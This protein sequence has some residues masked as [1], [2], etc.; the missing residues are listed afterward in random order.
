MSVPWIPPSAPPAQP[1]DDGIFAPASGA[2]EV[3][4]PPPPSAP[5]APKRGRGRPPGQRNLTP[6]ERAQRERD[7]ANA[8]A[9]AASGPSA[10]E[11]LAKAKA[12]A[13]SIKADTE[14]MAQW[15]GEELNDYIMQA[16]I[17]GGVPATML[18]KDG[19]IPK[20]LANNDKYTELGNMLAIPP[21]LAE[22]AARLA[23]EVKATDGGSKVAAATG[24]GRAGLVVAGIGTLF[25]TVTYARRVNDV[26]KRLRQLE[27]M[28][29]A[30]ASAPQPVATAAEAMNEGIVG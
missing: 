1:A 27:E 30:A 13:A 2:S 18:Y 14:E 24:N 10:E 21:N 20:A 29:V 16:L 28:R 19:H 17:T 5:E 6:L 8:K 23:A 3:F 26:V 9:A 25:G 22:S 4:R 7:A 11:V 15:I 12:K